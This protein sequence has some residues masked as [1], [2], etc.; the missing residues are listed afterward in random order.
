MLEVGP[1]FGPDAAFSLTLLDQLERLSR[2]PV[3]TGLQRES[4]AMAT[5]AHSATAW[6]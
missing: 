2:L 5:A 1:E 6:D 3:L 4:P